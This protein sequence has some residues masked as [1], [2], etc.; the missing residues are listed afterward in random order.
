MVSFMLDIVRFLFDLQILTKY[1]LVQ[2]RE[3]FR[4][5]SLKTWGN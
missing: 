1:I 4:R 2:A 3:L 5:L